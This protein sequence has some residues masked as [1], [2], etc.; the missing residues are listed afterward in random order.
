MGLGSERINESR[1]RSEPTPT[2]GEGT[3]YELALEGEDLALGHQIRA[4]VEARTKS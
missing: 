4:S 3:N 2:P 1:V